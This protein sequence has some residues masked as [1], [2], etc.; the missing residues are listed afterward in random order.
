MALQKLIPSGLGSGKNLVFRKL[1]EFP[2]QCFGHG[3]QAGEGHEGVPEGNLPVHDLLHV[4]LDVL[5]IGGDDGAVVM[6]VRVLI[7]LTFIE[8]RRIE[9]KVRVCFLNQPLHMSMGDLGRVAFRFRRD[10]LDAHLV[11][12]VGGKRGENHPVAKLSKEGCPE[13]V[14]LVHV[15]NAGNADSAARSLL[16]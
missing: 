7:F 10:G 9:N 3:L 1:C 2:N 8:Q 6:V 12:G 4:V 15:Q 5:R 16:G 13:G 14:I 11:N